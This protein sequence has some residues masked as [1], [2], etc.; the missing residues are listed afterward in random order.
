MTDA[1]YK[2]GNPRLKEAIMV[3][4][5][6]TDNLKTLGMK[7]LAKLLYFVDFNHY[8][9]T[10]KSITGETYERFDHGPMPSSLYE[11]VEQLESEGVITAEKGSIAT[12]IEKWDFEITSDFEPKYLSSH[13]RE[14]II[15]VLDQLDRLSANQ[16]E[17]L[18]HRDTPWQVTDDKDE[19]DY[20]L[21][22]YRDEEIEEFFE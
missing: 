1:Q 2:P 4:L 6:N 15:E 22:F 11:A 12:G 9:E 13:H 14:K 7:K 10:F 20:T 19:I 8:Q 5:S 21:V 16:L 3:I 18:S 17:K